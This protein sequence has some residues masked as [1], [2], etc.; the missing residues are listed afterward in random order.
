[1]SLPRDYE[2]AALNED[3]FVAI[4]SA[5]NRIVQ[6]MTNKDPAKAPPF[7]RL[8]GGTAEERLDERLGPSPAEAAEAAEAA[9][10]AESSAAAAAEATA[11]AEAAAQEEEEPMTRERLVDIQSDCCAMDIP[12]EECMLGWTAAQVEAFFDSG[13]TERPDH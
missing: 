7:D 1:M 10:S 3:D 2:E 9:A 12:V 13:G 5:H 11:A 6:A 8:H 4:R